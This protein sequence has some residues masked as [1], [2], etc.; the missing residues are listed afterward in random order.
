MLLATIHI[1]NPQPIHI[2]ISINNQYFQNSYINKQYIIHTINNGMEYIIYANTNELINILFEYII[3]AHI[4]KVE[5]LMN[6]AIF[7][8]PYE[9][10]SNKM[11]I[12]MR[13]LK[14]M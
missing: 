2:S 3:T 12:I 1:Y 6:H 7:I 4:I 13:S 14:I 5:P 8:D 11:N 9:T 10:I